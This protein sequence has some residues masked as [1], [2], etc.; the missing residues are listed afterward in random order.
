MSGQLTGRVALVTGGA[1]GLGE[2]IA[3]RFA[4][5]GATVV[6]GDLDAAGAQAVADSIVARG[7]NVPFSLPRVRHWSFGTGGRA[8]RARDRLASA[9][10]V[11][12]TF[13]LHASP[14]AA[15]WTASVSRL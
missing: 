11:A 4:N 14:A 3:Q 1:S 10:C 7:H 2:A 15:L 8:A 5:E 6:I 13:A 12:Y 9:C